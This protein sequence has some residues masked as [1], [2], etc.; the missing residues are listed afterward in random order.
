MK[1][2]MYKSEEVISLI[3]Q[4]RN[5]LLAGDEE[6]LKA[7]PKGNWIGGSIPYFMAENGGV[8]SKDL[9]QVDEIPSFVKEV[10]CKSYDIAT[11]K[12]VY[13]DGYDNGFS[14]IIIPGSSETHLSFAINAPDYR[15]FAT[16]P[17]AG[18][19]SGVLLDELGKKTPK[20]FIGSGESMSD[21]NAVVMH[22]KLPDNKYA[23]LNIV[24]IFRQGDGDSIE[25]PESGFNAKDALIN[26][27]KQNFAE[28]CTQKKLDVRL[29]LVAD[30]NSTMINISFQSVDSKEKVVN[31]Y[32]PV[33][34]GVTYKQAAPVDNYIK[35]FTHLI[36]DMEVNNMTFSCN[37]ILNFIYSELEGK[38]TG[39]ITGPITFGEIAYQLLNQTL[40]N[41]EIKDL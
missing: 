17:L 1:K 28:Y 4:G 33:F 38:K 39:T 32:A 13:K 12:N 41:L 25:F 23:D 8:I 21:R 29:P 11:I 37:C 30:Y 3:K 18:W 24:N 34:K 40:V 22:V 5:L 14:V 9:I 19:I 35:E 6:L 36:T 26:G 16:K 10:T 2:V 7:L 15:D 31:F 20:T 27:K